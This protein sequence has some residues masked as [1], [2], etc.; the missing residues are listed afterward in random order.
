MTGTLSSHARQAAAIALGEIDPESR[1]AVLGLIELLKDED[2]VVR[3]YGAQALGQMGSAASEAVPALT[4]LLE[5][6]DSYVR[7][8][9]AEALW[10]LT[11]RANLVLPA[12]IEIVQKHEAKLDAIRVLALLGK[13]ATPAIPALRDSLND[14]YESVRRAAAAA[15]RHLDPEFTGER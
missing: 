12:L 11:H 7:A 8:S 2:F 14:R 15:L 9:A 4:D 1:P 5:D 6:E 10:K 3:Y 13:D